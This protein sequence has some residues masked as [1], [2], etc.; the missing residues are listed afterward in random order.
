MKVI[1]Y[2]EPL[3]LIGIDLL[4]ANHQKGHSFAYIG[5]NPHTK[6]GEIVF[7]KNQGE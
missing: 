6:K 5:I 3:V 2:P 4:G 1:N 7:S